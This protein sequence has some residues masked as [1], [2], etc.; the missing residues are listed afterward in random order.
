MIEKGIRGGICHAI[1]KYA[2]ANNKYMK[3]YGEGKESSFLEYLDANNLYGYAMSQPLPTDEIEF[4]K[5][6]SKFNEAFIKNFDENSDKGYI[7]DV[8]IEYPKDLHDL[9]NHLPFLSKRMKIDKCNK[10]IC[11]LYDKNNYV[12]HIRSLKQALN[13]G[14]IFKKV[15]RVIQFNQEAWLNPYVHMNTE[16]RK[17]VKNEFEKDFFKLI[18]NSVFDKT[19]ENVGK[20]RE[21][22]LV[23]GDKRRSQLVSEPNYH[24]TKWFS[25]NLLAIEMKKTK[26]KMNKPV[27]LGFSIL[28]IIKTLMNEF[29]R[30]DYDR[31]CCT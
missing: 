16:L 17:Q 19:S 7:F 11:N 22:K 1:Y 3:N 14:L 18:N 28:D 4:V 2:K 8:D 13:H 5:N 10:L 20:Q 6:N 29:W 23:I 21:I 15:N 26:L 31:I 25:E 24:T 9:H 27:Y 12:V 30:R